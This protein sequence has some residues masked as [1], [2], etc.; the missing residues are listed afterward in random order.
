MSVFLQVGCHSNPAGVEDPEQPI[1]QLSG[2][3]A[4]AG[5]A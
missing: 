3:W 2:G 4:A 5:V 1:G